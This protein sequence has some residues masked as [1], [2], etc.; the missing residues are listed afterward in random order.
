MDEGV[1]EQQSLVGRRGVCRGLPAIGESGAS[2]PEWVAPSTVKKH[3]FRL[4]RKRQ[5]HGLII[6]SHDADKTPTSKGIETEISQCQKKEKTATWKLHVRGTHLLQL[7]QD[8]Y[9]QH[10]TQM[11]RTSPS[12]EGRIS[13]MDIKEPE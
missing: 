8:I 1:R 10:K 9:V 13:E 11:G 3:C 5:Q 4:P 6:T 2:R 12:L 7:R